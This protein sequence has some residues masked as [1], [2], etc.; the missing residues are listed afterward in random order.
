M[1]QG[2]PGV[3]IACDMG[4]IIGSGERNFHNEVL[5]CNID[6]GI[7]LAAPWDD[8][9]LYFLSPDKKYTFLNKT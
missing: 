4:N 3:S 2:G 8:T 7:D 6:G 5:T 9:A 1:I